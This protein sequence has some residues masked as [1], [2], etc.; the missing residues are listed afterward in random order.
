MY[1]HHGPTDIYAL[2]QRERPPH[3]DGFWPKFVSVDLEDETDTSWNPVRP[4]AIVSGPARAVY[5][6]DKD[7][8]IT[9][10]LRDV[11]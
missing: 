8:G 2:L 1:Q 4:G 11:Q 6:E 10:T 9:L 3:G 7:G 5:R